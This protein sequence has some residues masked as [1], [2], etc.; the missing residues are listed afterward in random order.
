[1]ALRF[2]VIGGAVLLA[3][4][5]SVAAALS[6]AADDVVAI[7]GGEDM[8]VWQKNG[9]FE[10]LVTARLGPATPR[11]RYLAWEGDTV[12]EQPRDLNF[13][14][15]PEQLRR[16]GATILFCQFGQA[17]SL[18]GRAGV[19]AFLTAYE[20]L[21]EA[22][23]SH[24]PRVV[25]LSPTP[26]E[27]PPGLALDAA[28]RNATLALYVEAIEQLA[29]RRQLV[30]VDLYRPLLPANG[31]GWR[32]TRD[33][34]HLNPRGHWLAAR[35]TAR[36]LGWATDP[37]SASEPAADG[38]LRPARLESLRQLI[39]VKN[40]LWFDYWRPQNWAFLAG[41]RTEQPSSRDHRDPT[42]RWFPAEMN[43]FLPRIAAKE[44]EIAELARG[45]TGGEE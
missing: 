7:L 42:V 39:V 14:T 37:P 27:D 22:L 2:L 28:G 21:L 36:Q 6:P 31:R 45:P 41:D 19:P 17:E 24:A 32:L 26:F 13:P 15:W 3:G 23:T 35:H 29:R 16:V 1:M 43:E 10:T 4:A 44:R 38:A 18:G 9:Y 30:F 33:G 11:F 5:A 25:L 20:R 12:F 40:Q 8:V 34:L